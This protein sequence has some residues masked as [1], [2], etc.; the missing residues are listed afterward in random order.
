[1]YDLVK[2]AHFVAIIIWIVS[3]IGALFVLRASPKPVT[4]GA[5]RLLM[6][7]GILLTWG[8]GA[9]LAY[10][11]GHYISLWFW[12]KF[13]I[14][15]LLSGLHGKIAGNLRKNNSFS[16]YNPIFAMSFIILLGVAVV[17][18]LAVAKP[19]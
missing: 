3:M 18:H 8:F 17:L 14:V 9:Y 15:F 6:T 12:V 13:T 1:M 5:F 10:A 16:S 19:F 4:A 2:H 7:I 11:G